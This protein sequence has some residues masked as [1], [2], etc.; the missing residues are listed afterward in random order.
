MNENDLN[1]QIEY[2][3]YSAIVDA[4]RAGYDVVRILNEAQEYVVM[5]QLRKEI[6]TPVVEVTR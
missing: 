5:S 3:A 1:G 6:Q 4:L 2:A